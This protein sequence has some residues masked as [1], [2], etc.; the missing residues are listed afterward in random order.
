[1]IAPWSQL[2]RAQRMRLPSAGLAHTRSAP[3]GVLKNQS[4]GKE[5]AAA[6]L[7]LAF[8]NSEDCKTNSAR[9]FPRTWA[10]SLLFRRCGTVTKQE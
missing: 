9:R 3:C 10:R 2:E 7:T 6:T 8:F 5:R 4:E 1:V